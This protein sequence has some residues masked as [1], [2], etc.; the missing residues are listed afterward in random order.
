MKLIAIRAFAMMV[1][2]GLGVEVEARAP[3]QEYLRLR[4]TA[5]EAWFERPSLLLLEFLL[6]SAQRHDPSTTQRPA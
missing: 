5:A 2:I 3:C 4:N 6:P 1:M